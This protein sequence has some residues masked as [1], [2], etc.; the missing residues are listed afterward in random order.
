MGAPRRRQNF[1]LTDE[2]LFRIYQLVLE[3][4][5]YPEIAE[6]VHCNLG[7][8]YRLFGPRKERP[9]VRKQSELRLSM[10][11]RE[12]ISRYLQE[13]LS[14]RVIAAR[15]GRSP[16]TVCREVHR[17]GGRGRYRAWRADERAWQWSK[18]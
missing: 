6:A 7:T 15:I 5:R 2:E 16:S 17:D 9:V 10:A 12:E 14:F 11:E 4:K 8:I 3:G 18:R 13:G 1:R